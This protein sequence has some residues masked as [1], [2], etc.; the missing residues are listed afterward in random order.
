MVITYRTRSKMLVGECWYT[1]NLDAKVDVARFFHLDHPSPGSWV[2]EFVTIWIDLT[3]PDEELLHAMT[4]STRYEIRRAASDGL[5]YENWY[6]DAGEKIEEFCEFFDSFAAA[7]NLALA[8]RQWLRVRASFGALDLSR[9]SDEHGNSLVWHAYYRD[10]EHV[11]QKYSASLFRNQ[12]DPKYRRLV[13]RANRYHH[14]QDMKQFK[15]EGIRLFDLGG[16]YP[17]TDNQELLKVNEFKRSFGGE[18]VTTYDCAKGV[19]FKGRLYLWAVGLRQKL[20]SQRQ[21]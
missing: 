14:W 3:K 8:D 7:K 17:G 12:P 20:A 4:E 6:A 19:T 9:V 21:K 16:C 18:I 2:E 15:Q 10:A 5:S 1:T 13:G 11:S